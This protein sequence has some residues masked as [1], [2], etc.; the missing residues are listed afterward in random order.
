MRLALLKEMRSVIEFDGSYVNY[1]H[2]AT[3]CD[4]MTAKGF[5]MSISRHGI[6]RID[7]SPLRKSSFEETVDIL[8]R[9]AAY[10]EYDHM[11]GVSNVLRTTFTSKEY[12]NILIYYFC[13]LTTGSIAGCPCV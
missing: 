5:I 9:G 3:L 11:R 8:L 4:I 2:L 7:S 1:R 13:Y 10:A 6:N 12:N